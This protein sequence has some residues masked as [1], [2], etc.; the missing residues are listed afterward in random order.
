M[1]VLVPMS[2]QAFAAFAAEATEAYAQDHVLAGNWSA[3]EALAKAT[4]QFDQLLPRGFDTPGHYFY[5]VHDSS[6]IAVGN[7]WFAAVGVGEVRSGYVYNIRIHP[8]HQRKGHGKAALLALESIAAEMHLPAIRLNVFGHNPRAEA[9][10]RS[11]GYEVTSSSM[12]KALGKN[13]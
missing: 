11:L 1:P 7:V 2:R 5:D 13:A 9:L 8:D 6:G 3:D 12:R 4:A 10:Y